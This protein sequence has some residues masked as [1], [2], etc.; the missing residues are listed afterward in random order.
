MISLLA[1]ELALTLKLVEIKLNYTNTH[2]VR[3][4][5]SACGM[6]VLSFLNFYTELRNQKTCTQR[7]KGNNKADS[8]QVKC[9][10]LPFFEFK[11]APWIPE[12]KKGM[13]NKN[14]TLRLI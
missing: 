8:S 12:I 13:Q 11:S 2:N 1:L 4:C 7:R 6:C 14:H 5:V 10:P 9:E 3:T